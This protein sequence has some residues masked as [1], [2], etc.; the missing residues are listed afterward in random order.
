MKTISLFILALIFGFSGCKEDRNLVEPEASLLGSWVFQSTTFDGVKE[1]YGHSCSS[2]KDYVEF[3]LG[4][5]LKNFVY[6]DDC[7][8]DV[9]KGTYSID[10]DKV[11]L[12]SVDIGTETYTF[13]ING[14]ILTMEQPGEV[15]ILVRK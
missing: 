5:E 4:G 14:K 13:K 2:K 6:E 9:D 1:D 12:R 10:G 7:S 15:T 3:K 11:T 8:E